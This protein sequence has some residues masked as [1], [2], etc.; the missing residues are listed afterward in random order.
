[1]LVCK[2][3][4]DDPYFSFF[5]GDLYVRAKIVKVVKDLGPD[6]QSH[7]AAWTQPYPG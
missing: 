6:W 4:D 7:P 1:M 3:K 5:G 2:S